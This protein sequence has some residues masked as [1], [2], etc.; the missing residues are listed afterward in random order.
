METAAI[1]NIVARVLLAKGEKWPD[2]AIA[3]ERVAEF[4]EGGKELSR[5]EKDEYFDRF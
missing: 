3:I 4:L 5:D 1:K 2:N